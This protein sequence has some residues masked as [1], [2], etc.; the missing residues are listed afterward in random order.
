MSP[1]PALAPLFHKTDRQ[2]A[3]V[4]DLAARFVAETERELAAESAASEEGE[5]EVEKTDEDWSSAKVDGVVVERAGSG[6]GE[7]DKTT[8]P[9]PPSAQAEAEGEPKL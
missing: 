8:P 3:T 5:V 7:K 4:A 9:P 1:Q 6:A 2:R